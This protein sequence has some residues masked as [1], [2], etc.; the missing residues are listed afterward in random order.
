MSGWTAAAAALLVCGVAP[1][2]WGAAIGPV[3]RRV[4]AQNLVTTLLSL[5]MLLLAQG[6]GRPA[7]T[8]PALV[9][10]VL[11]PA[12]TLLYVR[13]LA[14]QLAAHPPRPRSLLAVTALSYTAVPVV[15]LPLCVAASPGRATVKLLVIGALLVLGSRVAAR[16]VTAAVTSG[17]GRTGPAEG[18]ANG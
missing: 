6:Y 4:P 15:V 10:A 14:D 7:Y 13:L 8:D 11:G 3:R 9:L 12:G 1:A 18:M 17:H 5:V 2:A 16:A